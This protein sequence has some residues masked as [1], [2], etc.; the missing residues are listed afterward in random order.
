[1]KRPLSLAASALL[2]FSLASCRS[3]SRAPADAAAGS[4]AASPAGPGEA[5][6]GEQAYFEQE[7]RANP[8][9]PNSY[10]NLGNIY[11]MQ[12]KYAEAAEQ[13]RLALAK[14]PDDKTYEADLLTRLGNA[15]AALKQNE[16]AAAAYQKAVAANPAL[17]EP[18][19]RLADIYEQAG[20]A[21]D[22]ERER[23]EVV[24]LQPNETGKRL[25]VEG[26]L[27]EGLAELQKVTSKDAETHYLIGMGY[28]K[29]EQYADAVGAFRRAVSLDPKHA[30]AHFNLGNAYD[31]LNRHAEAAASFAEVVRL[32]P[33]AADANFNLGNAYAKLE[34]YREAAAAY[35]QA[36]R[37]EP[38]NA[39]ARL[40][41]AILH[42][43]YGNAEAATQQHTEL[44]RINPDAATRLEQ[45][46]KQGK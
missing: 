40:Q 25:L 33:A 12:G 29:L 28:Y 24:R 46:L 17:A 37:L 4:P 9:D 34:R 7:A 11:F 45:L 15:H 1:M 22:A 19:R 23:R 30:D 26:K 42:L 10:H 27:R 20:R 38:D 39:D 44:K 6:K 36:V 32:T 35:E 16:E 41:L 5:Y 31:R 3:E 14:H 43:R 8:D 21:A 13:Y 18:R 2:V